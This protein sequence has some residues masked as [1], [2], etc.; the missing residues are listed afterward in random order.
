MG[1]FP[2]CK[3]D[4]TF[5][6]TNQLISLDYLDKVPESWKQHG[7]IFL[8]MYQREAMYIQFNGS[9][10]N[11]P[12]AIKVAIGKVNAISGETWNQQIA[13]DK[14]DVSIHALYMLNN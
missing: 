5:T 9:F 12:K 10:D 14:Q 3:V 13:D 11:Y 4:G 1:S 6:S 8:P 7:G 2:V